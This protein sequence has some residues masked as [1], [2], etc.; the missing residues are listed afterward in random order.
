MIHLR[1]HIMDRLPSPQSQALTRVVPR[2]ELAHW[3]GVQGSLVWG[4]GLRVQIHFVL[5]VFCSSSS[6]MSSL[7]LPSLSFPSF[8]LPTLSCNVRQVGRS[9]AF[10]SGG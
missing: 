7:T 5:L 8:L 10:A 6:S 9:L 2:C 1:Y 3:F 4:L